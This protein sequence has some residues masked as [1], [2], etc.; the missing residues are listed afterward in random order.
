MKQSLLSVIIPVYNTGDVVNRITDRVLK[1]PMRDLELILIDDGSTNSTL[2]I[3]RRIEKSDKRVRVITQ[4]NSGPS[5]AR[6]TGL[7]SA[8]GKFILFL[9]S[10]DDIS[11]DMIVEMMKKQESTKADLVICAIKEV[12]PDGK[13]KIP[14]IKPRSIDT[15]KQDVVVFAL[16][17]MGKEGSVIYNPVNR[18]MRNNIIKERNL[19]YQDDLWLGEDTVFNLEYL[20]YTKKI[21]VMNQAFYTYYRENSTSVFAESSLD[22]NSRQ[23]SAALLWKFAKLSSNPI[24]HDLATWVQIRWFLSFCRLVCI[25]KLEK[26]EQK[27]RIFY[28]CEN[29]SLER[30]FNMESLSKKQQ[31]IAKVT[32][33]LIKHPKL[34]Y[35]FIRTI[36]K[37]PGLIKALT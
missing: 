1:Q 6:N 26:A 12:F 19:R 30:I 21:E 17:S 15:S 8:K 16:D 20:K 29:E 7:E 3:L 5:V 22:Y 32:F 31:L 28:A 27:R 4:K 37:I 24:A 36:I 18:I 10:D 23:K 14:K 35:N 33:S 13:V 2:I 9:D 25:S 34:L 11:T